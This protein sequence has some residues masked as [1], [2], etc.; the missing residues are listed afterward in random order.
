[1]VL[2]SRAS[3]CLLDTQPNPPKILPHDT[4]IFLGC[5]ILKK[6]ISRMELKFF[7]LYLIPMR[8]Y[9]DSMLDFNEKI[10]VYDCYLSITVSSLKSR[11]PKNF[12]IVNFGHP[13]S[14]SW[15]R[16]CQQLPLGGLE[17]HSLL[18]PG[19][20]DVNITVPHSAHEQLQR[21]IDGKLIYNA[22]W[23]S[24]ACGHAAWKRSINPFIPRGLHDKCRLEL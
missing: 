7:P 8:L 24:H 13:V 21:N 10:H 16:P 14:K 2:A 18:A 1:M 17:I 11:T 15:L 23:L 4:Q 9:N 6:S 19:Y 12:T 22:L 3:G 20:I 5:N